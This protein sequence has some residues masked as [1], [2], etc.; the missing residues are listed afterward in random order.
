MKRVANLPTPSKN[1]RPRRNPNSTPRDVIKTQRKSHDHSRRQI[2]RS[3]Q[4]RS[5]PSRTR[6]DRSISHHKTRT[7][8][9]SRVSN[10]SAQDYQQGV[11][12]Q[13]LI[14]A[15]CNRIDDAIRE[16]TEL[17]RLNADS[18]SIAAKSLGRSGL[19]SPD[20]MRPDSVGSTRKFHRRIGETIWI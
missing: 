5:Q 14:N 2:R 17:D 11:H 9:H 3:R 20:E 1:K 13:R 15:I 12:D 19:E 8:A 4:Q 6:S 10:S 16:H 18:I 7:R